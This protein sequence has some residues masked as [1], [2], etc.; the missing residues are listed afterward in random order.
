[1]ATPT[2]ELT[3]GTFQGDDALHILSL[4]GG[5]SGG[6]DKNGGILGSSGAGAA[7]AGSVGEIITATVASGSA[8]ALTTATSKN[9]TSISVTPGD[10]DIW[11]VVDLTLTGTTS[12]IQEAG[13]SLT[14][15][16]LASQAGGSGLG[17]DPNDILATPFTTITG[18]MSLTAETTLL[19]SATT[20]L[21]LVANVTFSAGT[22]AAYGSV[23]ARRR[24]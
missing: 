23:F 3:I 15:N 11:G 16:T 20:T 21:Y 4:G 19:I 10:W 13:L 6:L 14:T 17:T 12:T 1:M 5:V 9:V 8:T 7:V 2:A 22:V 24:R 18:T